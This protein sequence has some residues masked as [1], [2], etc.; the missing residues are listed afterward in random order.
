MASGL[1]PKTI[2]TRGR[3]SMGPRTAIGSYERWA[4]KNNEKDLL[5]LPIKIRRRS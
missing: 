2:E 5:G 3:D 1:V 4:A